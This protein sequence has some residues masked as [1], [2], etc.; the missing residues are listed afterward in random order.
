MVG[1]SEEPNRKVKRRSILTRRKIEEAALQ[2]FSRAGFLGASTREIAKAAGVKQQLITYHYGCKLS[3]WKTVVDELFSAC[4]DRIEFKMR[5]APQGLD[6][7]GHLRLVV[8]E[9]LM[10]QAENPQL[11]RVLLHEGACRG[12]RLNWLIEHHTRD[13]FSL[14]TQGF[15]L[16]QMSGFTPQGSPILLSYIL[17]GSAHMFGQGAEFAQITGREVTDK[18]VVEE[19]VELLLTMLLPGTKRPSPRF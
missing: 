14:A 11:S 16:A 4:R 2:A 8:Q 10:F 7:V 13:L 17:I 9:F 3:L 19:Y 15:Q 6:G 18:E 12:P 5:D 1:H